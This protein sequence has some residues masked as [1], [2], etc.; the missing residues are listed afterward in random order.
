MVILAELRAA[1]CQWGRHGRLE[2]QGPQEGR[3][4]SDPASPA[5]GRRQAL[6]GLGLQAESRAL[7]EG[8][9]PDGT[10]W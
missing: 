9:G 4:P 10:R 1:R 3:V 5:V 8:P 7:G 2:W 6:S